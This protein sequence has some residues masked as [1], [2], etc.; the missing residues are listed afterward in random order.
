MKINF[1]AS[2][3][4][5][6][7][8][9][10]AAC[11]NHGAGSD[12][13]STPQR[14]A[15]LQSPVQKTASYSP[16]AL[17]G[18][19]GSNNLGQT[20]LLSLYSPVCT[21]EVYHIEYQTVDLAGTLT[22]GSGALMVPNGLNA[23]CRGGRPIVLYAHATATNRSYNI[24][25]LT[26]SGHDEGLLMAAVF[27]AAGYIV[28]APNY[29]GYDTSTL[30]YHPY[31]NAD[32]QSKDMIDA[33]TAAR[34]ALPTSDALLT[35]DG[36]KLFVTGYSQGGFVAV[37]THRAMQAAGMVVTA[38]A[39]MSG[40][41][42]LSAFG[43][44]VFEGE[45]NMGAPIDLTL[46]ISGYQHAY[47][48]M[49]TNTTDVFS[50]MYATGIDSLLPS[51]TALGV[52]ESEGKIPSS[53]LFDSTPPASSYAAYTPATAPANLAAVFAAGFGANPLVT[54]SY[55]ASY[56]QDALANP[57]GGFPM[58]TDGLPPAKPANTLRQAFKTNDLRTWAPTV[59]VLLC[60]GDSDPTVFYF[61]TQLLQAYWA[62]TAP[63]AQVTVLDIDSATTPND[64][65]SALKTGFT[66]AK[67]A[68]IAS[69]VAGGATD[70]G[71]SAV[72]SHYHAALVPPFCLSAA[73][74]FFDGH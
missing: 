4:A 40:P 67:D 48:N 10:M 21:I 62:A 9:V 11:S 61:N 60:G 68:L 54:N 65:Y 52:L 8:L 25:D 63:A 26:A 22:P 7:L 58:A 36:G 69:A 35:T 64:P 53:V 29:V 24:A 14:G 50:P 66:A 31:L 32:Q 13:P 6:A 70:G 42:A 33:L 44:A 46:L 38:A 41:Y 49:Y 16:T 28:V 5:A 23:S 34:S 20:L 12:T 56:L 55:R 72:L 73:K 57:D 17:L 2:A 59:P 45:V 47:G 37:A 71:L 18:L 43:D 51:A 27:A 3:A 74:S 1:R 15:L 39:P 19:L 30:G